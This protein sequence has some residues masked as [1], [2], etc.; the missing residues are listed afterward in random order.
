M[1]V[2]TRIL[3]FDEAAHPLALVPTDLITAFRKREGMVHPAAGV[4]DEA[5]VEPMEILTEL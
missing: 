2:D 1:V 4:S 3:L 5:E